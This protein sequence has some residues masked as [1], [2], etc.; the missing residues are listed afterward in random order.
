VVA[1]AD[2]VSRIAERGVR[3]ARRYGLR[4]TLRRLLALAGHV[5]YLRESHIWYELDL[6]LE[7]PRLRLADR[8]ELRR[9]GPGEVELLEKLPTVGVREARRRLA[10]GA[11]LWLVRDGDEAASACWIFHGRTPASCA[12]RGVLELPQRTV[13]LEDVVTSE[14][15]RGQGVAP[16]AWSTIARQ[17]G[18]E[19]VETIVVK[20]ERDNGSSRRAME[21]TGFRE[22]AATTYTRV[23]PYARVELEP[24]GNGLS[25]YLQ[26]TLAR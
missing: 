13:C 18:E 24:L 7:Q 8:F 15:Y 9:A 6:P 25:G 1:L 14:T 20:V 10:E 21:K 19:G 23:G 4:G 26:Q 5:V 2:A 11:E 16:A 12:P 3:G 17:L 22:I